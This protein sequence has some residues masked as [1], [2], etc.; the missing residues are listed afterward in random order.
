[1]AITIPV[2]TMAP[3]SSNRTPAARPV[4]LYEIPIQ[5]LHG[6]SRPSSPPAEFGPHRSGQQKVAWGLSGAPSR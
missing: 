1:M 6:R 4:I 5:R 2:F 3:D